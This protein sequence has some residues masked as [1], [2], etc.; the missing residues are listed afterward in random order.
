MLQK[1][2]AICCPWCLLSTGVYTL[3][4]FSWYK[5]SIP[6]HE[7]QPSLCQWLLKRLSVYKRKTYWPSTLLCRVLQ[8]YRVYKQNSMKISFTC[9]RL[10]TQFQTRSVFGR[11]H[12]IFVQNEC[13]TSQVCRGCSWLCFDIKTYWN[14]GNFLIYLKDSKVIKT[15][16]NSAVSL[17]AK[18]L[19]VFHATQGF[20]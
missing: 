5:S 13:S 9:S 11:F 6:F 4:K 19:A 8:V 1:P 18:G 3:I 7:K 2:A 10:L 12:S 15:K 20:C 16:S 14:I 17:W